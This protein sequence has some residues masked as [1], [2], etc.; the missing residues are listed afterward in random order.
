MSEWDAE[1]RG[2]CVGSRGLSSDRASKAEPASK[3]KTHEE[4]S[5]SGNCVTESDAGG[6]S[7]LIRPGNYCTTVVVDAGGGLKVAREDNHFFVEGSPCAEVANL[8]SLQR[9]RALR[10]N[11]TPSYTLSSRRVT[12]TAAIDTTT[13]QYSTSIEDNCAVRVPQSVCVRPG[14]KKTLEK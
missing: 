12:P 6:G 10:R 5:Y 2:L 11:L 1:T 14:N 3:R 13:G 9:F 7:C 4:T 8:N